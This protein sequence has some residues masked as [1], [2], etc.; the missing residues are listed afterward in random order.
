MVAGARNHRNRLASPSWWRSSDRQRTC[1][2]LSQK[3]PA[4]SN[5]WEFGGNGR[6]NVVGK[7][8]SDRF[9]R[10]PS[11]G[12]RVVTQGLEGFSRLLEPVFQLRPRFRHVSSILAGQSGV[13]SQRD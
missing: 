3:P 5:R 11:A 8:E 7:W 6:E 13:R 2:I 12:S 4:S 9:S 1:P 10:K